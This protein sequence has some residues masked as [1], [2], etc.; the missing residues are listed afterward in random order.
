MRR[1]PSS[2]ADLARA[3]C[4][5]GAREIEAH[6]ELHATKCWWS[7]SIRTGPMAVNSRSRCLRSRLGRWLAC[8]GLTGV[9]PTNLSH[10]QGLNSSG[11]ECFTYSRP[12]FFCRLCSTAKCQQLMQRTVMYLETHPVL[13]G[14][15]MPNSIASNNGDRWRPERPRHGC[16]DSSQGR[17]HVGTRGRG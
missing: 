1:L 5:C 3:A 16:G 7:G 12:S 10:I 8:L 14:V 11:Y 4:A 13:L 15:A 6:A 2:G 9:L 17:L